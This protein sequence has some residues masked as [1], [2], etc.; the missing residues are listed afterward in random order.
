MLLISQLYIFLES[1]LPRSFGHISVALFIFFI[2]ELKEWLLF[3]N[4]V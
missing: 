4:F 1:Y 2:I 3:E